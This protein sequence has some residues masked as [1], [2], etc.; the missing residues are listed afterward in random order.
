MNLDEFQKHLV[1]TKQPEDRIA[2]MIAGL[3]DLQEFLKKENVSLDT[4]P[5]GTLVTYTERLVSTNSD[6]VMD[7]LIGLYNYSHF[8][9]KPEYVEEIIDLIE[10]HTAMATLYT[11]V[12]EVHGEEIRDEIFKDVTIPPV[13]VH[14]EKKPETT[15][16]VIRRL[17]EKIGEEKTKDLLR[18]CLHS[19]PMEPMLKD[20]ET[21]LEMNDLDAFLKQKHQDIVAQ[22]EKNRDDGTYWF[23]QYVDDEVVDF[24]RKT[25]TMGAG[26]REGNTIIVTK[27]PYQIKKYLH[28]END[29]MKKFYACYC[30]WVRGAIKKGEENEI[31]KN[32]CYCSGGFFKMYWDVIFDQPVTVE[33]LESP[34]T[35]H[36]ICK[37]AVQIPDKILAKENKD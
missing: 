27:I 22:A 35:G 31:S 24:V 5:N 29:Q 6:S 26:V 10:S 28:A 7:V 23:A 3:K 20:K 30:P 25:Q 32:F 17:E 15:K 2:K 14:P 11:R 12:A 4:I 37:F 9:K 21:Y 1:S 33:L 19:R 16:I 34:L 36:T 13:G 8:I 18:P